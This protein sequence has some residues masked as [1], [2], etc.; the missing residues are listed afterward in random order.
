MNHDSNGFDMLRNLLQL[1]DDGQ[2]PITFRLKLIGLVILNGLAVLGWESMMVPYLVKQKNI[3]VETQ[4][5]DNK[6]LVF[7]EQ[8]DSSITIQT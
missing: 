2:V 3:L 4:T 6:N 5:T 8:S 1:R 7:Y